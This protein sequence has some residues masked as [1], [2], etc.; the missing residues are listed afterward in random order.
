MRAKARECC[1]LVMVSL[2]V[3]IPPSRGLEIR[4][5]EVVS[6]GDHFDLPHFKDRNAVVM[7]DDGVVLHFHNYKTKRFT[8]RDE[9]VLEVR[10]LVFPALSRRD[11]MTP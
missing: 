8:G 2:Y 9:L 1:D 7:K 5:L 3:F 4:T 10:G 11:I 6:N